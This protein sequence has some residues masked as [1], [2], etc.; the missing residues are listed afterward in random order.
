MSVNGYDGSN[1]IEYASRTLVDAVPTA[2]ST[3]AVSSG[4]VYDAIDDA[5]LS[6]RYLKS[7]NLG[8]SYT[9]ELKEDIQS[10]K[11]EKAIVGGYLK[12][13]GH[14]YD[15]AHP[16]YFLHSGD[17]RCTTHHM[18]VVPQWINVQGKMNSTTTTTGGYPG[19]D[20]KTGNNSNTAL[21][22]ITA[23]IEADFGAENILHYREYF[24]TAVTDGKPSG[25]AYVDAYIELMNERMVYG[26]P[27]FTVANDGT[28]IPT[29]HTTSK[30]QLEL[31][32]K[33][34]DLISNRGDWWLCGPVSARAFAL[35]GKDGSAAYSNASNSRDIRP[36][37][38]I[39]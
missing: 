1:L 19:S 33:R 17:T 7:I 12:I 16:D 8:T 2:N 38:A 35:V 31:F 30:T 24:E 21:A 22:E 11:F 15:F 18:V 27:V 20:F 34:P 5:S 13:N 39:C 36:C 6:N 14:R 26:N 4:G 3:R 29:V 32:A 37:F 9:T 10:G 28:N 25:G 23:I